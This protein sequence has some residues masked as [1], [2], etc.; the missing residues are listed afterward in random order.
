MATV[1]TQETSPLAEIFGAEVIR[2]NLDR[3]RRGLDIVLN[4]ESPVVGATPKDIVYAKGTQRLYRYRPLTD[5]VYRIP[6]VLVMSLISKPYILDLSP[7]QS[8]VE[9]LLR[10]GFD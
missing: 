1:R 10:E 3:T 2:R 8:M 7:G 4:R 6:V 5:E 9:Y